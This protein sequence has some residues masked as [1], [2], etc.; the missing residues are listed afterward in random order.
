MILPAAGPGSLR[1]IALASR[2]ETASPWPVSAAT[3]APTDRQV[4]GV[5]E[6]AEEPRQRVGAARPN[7]TWNRRRR[8][9]EVPRT[10]RITV[11]LSDDEHRQVLANAAAARLAPSTYLAESGVLPR[12]PAY[13]VGTSERSALLLEL[14]GLHRQVRGIATNLNQATARLHSWGQPVAELRTIA[15][16]ADHLLRAVDD[17]VA[18]LAAERSGPRD[19][20]RRA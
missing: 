9:D 6:V 17:A 3:V 13:L 1:S 16:T 20:P 18:R 8:R 11:R 4:T 5:I 10:R 7:A 2:G 14:M 12:R 15:A 19:D